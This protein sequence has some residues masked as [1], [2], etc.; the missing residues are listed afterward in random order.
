MTEATL[1]KKRIFDFVSVLPETAKKEGWVFRY[2]P[3]SDEVSITVPNLS[4]DARIR[5]VNDEIA[6]Y[7]SKGKI[8]GVFI[9]YFRKNFIEHQPN[10]LKT[11]AKEISH[12]S[13]DEGLVELSWDRVEKIA[14]DLDDSIKMAMVK[15]IP[16]AA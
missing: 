9:E 1:E 12:T 3:E 14:P 13:G 5:Y 16:S 6:L 2:D 8:Q 15:D 11:L 4:D 7:F 10:D